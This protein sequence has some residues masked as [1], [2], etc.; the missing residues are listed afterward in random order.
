MSVVWGILAAAA[1]GFGVNLFGAG[2]ETGKIKR[3]PYTA[4]ERAAI[5]SGRASGSQGLR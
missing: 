1:I 5:L 3:A 4:S 2:V